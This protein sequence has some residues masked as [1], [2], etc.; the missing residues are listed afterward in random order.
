ME[1]LF[2]TFIFFIKCVSF[3]DSVL[4]IR[5]SRHKECMTCGE[6]LE[7]EVIEPLT[8]APTTQ[9]PTTDDPATAPSTTENATTEA[10]TP[11]DP[12]VESEAASQ[13]PSESDSKTESS[14]GGSGTIG[15]FAMLLA[16][17]AG[18][19]IIGKKRK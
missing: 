4:H 13:D 17:A 7:T 6:T 1:V 8:E 12:T 16:L 18:C 10:T 2:M 14:G 19:A 15:T 5:G 3:C 11:D 9:E